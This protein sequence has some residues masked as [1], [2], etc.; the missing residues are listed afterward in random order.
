MEGWKRRQ[1]LPSGSHGGLGHRDPFLPPPHVRTKHQPE[2]ITVWLKSLW[3]LCPNALLW[4]LL[5]R[6]RPEHT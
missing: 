2:F 1:G 6:Q 4:H 5:L 3:S